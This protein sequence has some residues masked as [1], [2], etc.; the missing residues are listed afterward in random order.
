[1]AKA[2]NT[3]IPPVNKFKFLTLL[4]SKKPVKIIEIKIPCLMDIFGITNVKSPAV[5]IKKTK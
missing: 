3:T 5:A 1:M 2:I 4:N